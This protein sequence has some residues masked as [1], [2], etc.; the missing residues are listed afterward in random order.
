MRPTWS[1]ASHTPMAG[2]PAPSRVTSAS[3]ASGGHGTGSGGVSA[4]SRS[5]V[6]MRQRAAR[7]AR[8]PRRRAARAWGP[9]RRSRPWRGRPRSRAR[10][11]RRRAGG[12]RGGRAGAEA[13]H[14]APHVVDAEGD[15][16]GGLHHRAQERLG[17]EQAQRRGDRLLL[18]QD[19]AVAAAPGEVVQGV[20]DVE[21]QGVRLL[22]ALGRAGETQAAATACIACTSRRPPRDSFR[23]GSS[24]KA[25]SPSSSQRRKVISRSSGSRRRASARQ[26]ASTVSRR[27]RVRSGSP[28]TWRA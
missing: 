27:P 8:P 13:C 6:A 5:T 1:S 11:R 28:A 20:P 14:A 24:R 19:E 18:L 21:E 16:A 23:S 12:V 2:A 7:P 9:S 4:A 10:R 15:D 3:R 25:S 22:D 26:S 17:V